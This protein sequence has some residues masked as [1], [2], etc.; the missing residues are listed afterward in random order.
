MGTNTFQI[1][2]DTRGLTGSTN[3]VAAGCINGVGVNGTVTYPAALYAQITNLTAV[4]ISQNG[5][6][7]NPNAFHYLSFVLETTL[8]PFIVGQPIA[9]TIAS[10]NSLWTNSVTVLADT[11][12][13]PIS[14]QWYANGAPLVNG[15]NGVSGANTNILTINPITPGNQFT[16][17]YAIIGNNFGS[18]TSTLAS[19]VILTNPVVTI[20]LAPSNS[21]TLFSGSGGNVGSSPTFA[22]SASGAPS[23][24]Y[25]WY[26][27]GVQVG[28]ATTINASSSSVSFT[29]IQGT[30]PATFACVVS[31]AFSEVTNTWYATYIATP[32]AAYPQAVLGALPFN[33]W[34]LNEPDNGLGNGNGGVVSHD[35]QSGNNG[36][37][38]NINLGQTGYN[39]A[40]PSETSAAFGT[41][42]SVFSY[43]GRIRGPDFAAPSG[44]NAEFTV[45]AWAF[46]FA[47]NTNSRLSLKARLT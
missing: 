14:Y 17:Y 4:G 44:S 28:G 31:N 11:N 40:E 25:R 42:N 8:K 22:V 1:I 2:L 13:G 3:W 7:S 35:Y 12:G 43:D 10:G 24:D 36:I 15:V 29:N 38:T 18:A 5:T 27:N 46:S 20:P 9:S 23:L 34:R 16:N 39:A 33:F 30:G 37:Y 41:Y 45:E 32:T 26:T 21:V 19:V 47:D 6:A